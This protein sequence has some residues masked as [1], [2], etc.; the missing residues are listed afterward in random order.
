[1]SSA[2]AGITACR[3]R[4]VRYAQGDSPTALDYMDQTLALAI[5][6]P[7]R[8]AYNLIFRAEIALE[9]GRHQDVLTDI[10]EVFKVGQSQVL[11]QQFLW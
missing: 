3:G 6:H 5:G 11:G 2:L 4:P 1:M 7:R 8:W 9:L 10:S